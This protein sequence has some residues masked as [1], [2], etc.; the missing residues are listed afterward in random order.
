MKLHSIAASTTRRSLSIVLGAIALAQ[1]ALPA[2]ITDLGLYQ[3]GGI[4]SQG[5][6]A[7][8]ILN[9]SGRPVAAV[10]SAGNVIAA[11]STPDS[12]AKSINA[13]GTVV[14]SYFVGSDE[15]AFVATNGVVTDLS[16]GYSAGDALGINAS[17]MVVGWVSS[18][19]NP[20]GFIY[21]PSTGINTS[22]GLLGVDN[23]QAT[24]INDSGQVTGYSTMTA[25][26]GHAFLLENGS[27]ADLGALGATG[28]SEG[29]AINSSGQVVGWSSVTPGGKLHAVEF[30]NGSITELAPGAAESAADGI[31]D[32]GVVVGSMDSAAFA[33][34]GG[35][36][37]DLNNLLPSNSGWELSEARAINNAGQI[38]GYGRLNGEFH[39]F[40][41]DETPFSAT[42]EPSSLSMLGFGLAALGALGGSR[43]KS[44]FG[45]FRI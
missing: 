19:S 25:T 34:Y 11:V 5:Q 16:T 42:P 33:Y 7:G 20:I 13:S 29:S 37:T 36:V 4:N 43:V 3:V 6:V 27:F 12:Q 2:H 21:N 15:H 10:W 17:G 14:G 26:S 30:A 18:N 45:R 28:A 40:L 9:N 23:L 1:P 32:R 22:L 38:V 41:L 39:T 35:V 31:N 44:V 24:A 8:S